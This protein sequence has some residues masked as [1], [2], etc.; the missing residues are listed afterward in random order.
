MSDISHCPAHGCGKR[1]EGVVAVCPDCG[2]PMLLARASRVRGWLLLLLG[3][4]LAIGMGV[5]TLGVLPSMLR[6]GV[7][8]ADGSRFTG[9]AEEARLFLT[10]FAGLVAFG[11]LMAANGVFHIAT[12]RMNRLFQVLG[13]LAFAGIVAIVWVV[14]STSK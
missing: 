11:L 9:T 6:P 12:G 7:E 10:L 13:L 3:L 14:L 8:M 2:G 1:V 5:I 4:S